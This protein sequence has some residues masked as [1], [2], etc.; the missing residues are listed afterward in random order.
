LLKF[1]LGFF[2][3]I[4]P[5]LPPP[6]LISP[7]NKGLFGSEKLPKLYWVSTN[8]SGVYGCFPTAL[9]SSLLIRI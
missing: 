8:C 7:F 9:K 4:V 6:N 3:D 1:I 2:I 5:S